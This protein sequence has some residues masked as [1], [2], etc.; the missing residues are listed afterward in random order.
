MA[1]KGGRGGLDPQFLADIICEQPLMFVWSRFAR[2]IIDM[3]SDSF[4][5]TNIVTL[6]KVF[7]IDISVLICVLE[8]LLHFKLLFLALERIFY[9][10]NLLL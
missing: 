5:F 7:L 4:Q 10:I 2:T 8:A 6:F 9:I 3:N 1:D